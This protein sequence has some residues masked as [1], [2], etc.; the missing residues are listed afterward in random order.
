MEP[1]GSLFCSKNQPPVPFLSQ[2]NLVCS[3]LSHFFNMHLCLGLPSVIFPSSFCTKTLYVFL[4]SPV[5]AAVPASLI[6]QTMLDGECKPWHSAL[7]TFLHSTVTSFL[8][9]WNISL[10]TLFSNTLSLCSSVT[11]NDQVAHPFK[12]TC[13]ATFIF[14]Y[15]NGN[16][17]NSELNG[18]RHFLDLICS[19][20][21]HAC[22]FDLLLSFP[23]IWALPHIQRI[24]YLSLFL[25]LS[26]ILFMRHAP[27]T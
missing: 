5:S 26:C 4:L 11:V 24:Y 10:S 3:L 15:T 25:I 6:F 22:S 9:H 12:A 14:L 20:F 21:I 1:T 18:R 23:N 13:K 19:K 8:I 27:Y 16:A 17:A 7:H 2:M